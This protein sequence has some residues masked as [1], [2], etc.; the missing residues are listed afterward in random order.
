MLNYY[1]LIIYVS[2]KL[3]A[4]CFLIFIFRFVKQWLITHPQ[5]QSNV[6][7]VGG[8]SYSG[9]VVPIIVEE[10]YNGNDFWVLLLELRP[11]FGLFQSNLVPE[12]L[13]IRSEFQLSNFL[14]GNKVGK[15][16]YLKLN[17]ITFIVEIIALLLELVL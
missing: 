9:I 11:S 15:E 3:R 2:N 12:K 6:L 10:I 13:S 4:P 7:Y 16:P 14:A 5:F 17:V 8:D 1:H